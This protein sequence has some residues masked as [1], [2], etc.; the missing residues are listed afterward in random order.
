MYII[1]FVIGATVV[2]QRADVARGEVEVAVGTR[3]YC[4]CAGSQQAG[5]T[6]PCDLNYGYPRTNGPLTR[7]PKS[8]RDRTMLSIPASSIDCGY[9]FLYCIPDIKPSI[10]V[11]RLIILFAYFKYASSAVLRNVFIV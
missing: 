3:R 10:H 5:I 6:S 9:S 1:C 8:S 4:S 7:R 11:S 2:V